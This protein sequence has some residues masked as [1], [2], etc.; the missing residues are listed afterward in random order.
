MAGKRVD[1][2]T[3]YWKKRDFRATSEPKGRAVAARRPRAGKPMFCVQRHAA[4]RL[5][6]DFR[7]EIDG[8]LKSWAVPKEPTMDPSIKR[9][10]VRTEDHPFEYGTF[11]GRIPAGQY[12][13]GIVHLHDV[14]EVAFEG[15]ASAALAKGKL[16]FVLRGKRLRGGFAMVRMSG[17][18]DGENWLLIKRRD[19]QAGSESAPTGNRVR[20]ARR[21][22]KRVATS[23]P[24]AAPRIGLAPQLATLVDAPPQGE[25]WIHEAKLDGYRMIATVRGKK[26]EL[27]SRNGIEW[28]AKVPDVARAIA[29]CTRED[30]VLD[31]E[32]VA[33]VRGDSTSF[34]ELREVLGGRSR[35]PLTF[36]AFD[37]LAAAGRDLRDE[38]WAAR[39]KELERVVVPDDEAVRFVTRLGSDGKRAFARACRAGLEGIISKRI[40]APYRSARTREWLK[41]KCDRRQ[42]F[43]AIG[44]TPPTHRA[45]SLGALVL[46]VHRGGVLE[47]CGKVGT[48]FDRETKRDLRR[49]LERVA[50]KTSPVT[51]PEDVDLSDVRFARPDLVVEVRFSE[52]TKDGRLRHPA[53]VG[54]R[55]DKDWKEV[56]VERESNVEEE[57]ASARGR[58]P[59]VTKRAREAAGS[60]RE[61]DEERHGIRLTS[62]DRVVFES[63]GTTKRDLVDYYAKAAEQFLPHVVKRPLSLLRCPGG[64][65]G[66]E[67]FFQKHWGDDRPAGTK[68]IEIREKTK[69]ASYVCVTDL[70]GVLELVQRGVIEFHPWPSTL[71]RIERPDRMVIDLDPGPG[72]SFAQLQS[73]ALAVRERL[74]ELELAACCLATGGKGI[75]VVTP[76]TRHHGFDEVKSFAH[77]IAR[78]FTRRAP[79]EFVAKA[80]LAAR[81]GRI[82]VDYL[83]NGRGATAIAPYSVRARERATIAIPLAWNALEHATKL[84]EITVTDVLRGGFEGKDPWPEYEASRRRIQKAAFDAIGAEVVEV[85]P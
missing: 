25:G 68:A 62:G 7:L 59:A 41:V 13:A 80:A 21:S 63:A 58:I 51:L 61:R 26:V 20:A 14:G 85:K 69:T 37:I 5:H 9:L 74:A 47:Y 10:A 30:A 64:Y 84:P 55:E 57:R 11:E 45:D 39:R 1:P 40:D 18:G 65:G 71:D 73:A 2:L 35:R 38:P 48:G 44:F 78:D 29:D 79:R 6:F 31:G 54:L 17:E 19:E 34:A 75:H 67:C 16:D 83:R 82:F 81:K 28:T 12:G 56:V 3:Q 8:V 77:A 50:R 15:D 27:R 70:R 53:F 32:L 4:S 43:V 49:R 24:R 23:R 60:T 36:V 76:L 46:A 42:E 66:E 33:F 52:W 72:V 22:R